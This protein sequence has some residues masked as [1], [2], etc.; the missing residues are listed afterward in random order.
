MTVKLL[1]EHHLGFLSLKMAAQARVSQHLSKCHIAGN[2]MLW[3]IYSH[4]Q[5]CNENINDSPSHTMAK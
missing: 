3:L 1:T 5:S 4:T 2:H